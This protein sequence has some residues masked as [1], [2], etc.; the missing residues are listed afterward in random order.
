MSSYKDLVIFQ[1]AYKLAIQVHRFSRKLPDFEKYEIGSQVRRSSMSVKDTIVEGYG[2]RKYKAEYVKYLTYAQA[3]CDETTT[4]LETINELYPGFQEIKD[5][6][7][8]YNELGKKINSYL[9]YVENNWIV[10][11]KSKFTKH[12]VPSTQCPAPSTQHQVP[13]TSLTSL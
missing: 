10:K 13:S 3:S 9:N 2:R 11:R 6:I 8:E 5:I 4:Q 7:K 1:M 12:P